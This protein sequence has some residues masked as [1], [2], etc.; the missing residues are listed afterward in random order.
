MIE[1][2]N[3]MFGNVNNMLGIINKM[4]GKHNKLGAVKDRQELLTQWGL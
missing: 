2:Y 4:L 3:I 1:I